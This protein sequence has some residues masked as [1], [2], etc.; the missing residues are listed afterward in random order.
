MGVFAELFLCGVI[1]VLGPFWGASRMLDP[2]EVFVIQFPWEL[3]HLLTVSVS[4]Y[5][6][7]RWVGILGSTVFIPL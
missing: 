4:S 3:T 1:R 6:A 2:A 7:S 5:Q